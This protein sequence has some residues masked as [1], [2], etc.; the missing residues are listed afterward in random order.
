MSYAVHLRD[1]RTGER[2]VRN[3]DLSWDGESS[4][5]WWREHSMSND[6]NRSMLMYDRD[7]RRKLS[8]SAYHNVIVVDKIVHHDVIVYQD[9]G[10]D[11][12]IADPAQDRLE[13]HILAGA[14]QFSELQGVLMEVNRDIPLA[15]E[16]ARAER[17]ALAQSGYE[18]ALALLPKMDAALEAAERIVAAEAAGEFLSET[19][20]AI[21]DQV[22]DEVSNNLFALVP[23]A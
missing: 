23:L 19:D 20:I 4:V 11:Q 18:P 3:M 9:E 10:A 12:P 8:F 7:R 22:G 1:R 16:Q 21:L 5:F 13:A 2:V 15:I 14:A 17:D 6:C